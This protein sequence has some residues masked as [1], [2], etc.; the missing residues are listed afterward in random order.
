VVEAARLQVVV[1]AD[2][3]KLDA[4]MRAA[5]SRVKGFAGGLSGALGGIASAAAAPIKA[6]GA[7]GLAGMGIS[8][9][10]SAA[11]S[12]SGVLGIGLNSSMENIR[13]QLTAMTKDG[14]QSAKILADIR[15]EADKTPFAFEEMARATA[16]LLPAAKQSGVALMDLVK[17]AEILA[18]S[19]PTSRRSSSGST[20]PVSA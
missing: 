10:T 12:L 1:E 17:Q 16:G 2:T 13:A 9:V 6:L 3:K 14:A 18:A 15:A 7:I 19:N 5:E 11:S 8:A 20:Y 4:G